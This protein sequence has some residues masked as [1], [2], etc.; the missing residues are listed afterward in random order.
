AAR[1]VRQATRS[2]SRTSLRERGR[3]LAEAVQ[4]AVRLEPE[5][6]ERGAA[7]VDPPDPETE[8]LCAERIPAVRRYESDLCRLGAQALDGE[9]I[10]L[11]RRL[12]TLP[13]LDAEPRVELEPRACDEGLDHVGRAVRENR[14]AASG[15]TQ[16]TQRNPARRILGESR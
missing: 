13:L 10:H 9:L 6:V 2:W 12:E 4:D 14:E 5:R 7:A 3:Q 1:A 16:I 8:R 11:R 15:C